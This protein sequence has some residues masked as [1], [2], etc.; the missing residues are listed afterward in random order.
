MS[1]DGPRP[2]LQERAGIS[3]ARLKDFR[4]RPLLEPNLR[5]PARGRRHQSSSNP[6]SRCRRATR[7][8]DKAGGGEKR[9]REPAEAR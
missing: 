7:E 2:T 4:A 9:R 6:S 5:G 1:T 8:G 3:R